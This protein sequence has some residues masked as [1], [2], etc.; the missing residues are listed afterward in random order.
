MQ[1]CFISPFA[2]WVFNYDGTINSIGT[3]WCVAVRGTNN[4]DYEGNLDGLLVGLAPCDSTQPNQLFNVLSTRGKKS[5]LSLTSTS[6]YCV[7]SSSRKLMMTLFNSIPSQLWSRTPSTSCS[8]LKTP[9]ACLNSITLYGCQRT[10][11]GQSCR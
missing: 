1:P 6:K 8:S 4:T 7:N 10:W 3:N 5:L 2:R 9:K 11:S